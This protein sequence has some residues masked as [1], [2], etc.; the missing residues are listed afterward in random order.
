[1]ESQDL[2]RIQ[3]FLADQ[4][5]CSR[6]EAET[7]I[8][9]GEVTVNGK[10]ATLG[11]KIDPRSDRVAVGGQGVSWRRPDPVTLAMH[12]PRGVICS[13]RDPH[14]SRTI[15]DLVPPPW[16]RMRL[17]CAGRLDKDSEGLLILTSEGDLSQRLTHPAHQVIKRYLVTLTRPFDQQHGPML[18]RGL[19]VEGELLK[20]EKVVPVKK[21]RLAPDTLEVHLGHGRKREIRR[22]LEFLGY[23]IDRLCRFQIGNL[24]LRGL[25]PG[26]VRL[27]GRK[28]IDLLFCRT[29]TPQNPV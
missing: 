22:M 28:D 18:L 13:N 11:Q 14:H 2:I 15:F 3:K 9:A 27:L 5:V 10:P 8:R 6:R 20:A 12:K 25:G 4:G 26:R 7:W 16:N 17:F 23:R 29:H 19:M 24:T 1:M 21:G